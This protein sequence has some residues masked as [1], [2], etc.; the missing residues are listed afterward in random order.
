M[1]KQ[2][3]NDCTFSASARSAA[4]GSPVSERAS[5]P[6]RYSMPASGSRSPS[7]VA[8]QTIWAST[9]TSAPSSRS[10]KRTALM[11][12]RFVSAAQPPR[13][14]PATRISHRLPDIGFPLT[15]KAAHSFGGDPT[16]EKPLLLIAEEP[17]CPGSEAS[18]R[19]VM[20]H[21][22]DVGSVDREAKALVVAA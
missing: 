9:V 16:D 2:Q 5:A 14:P 8:S 3:V 15:E 7:S 1:A 4:W 11:R 12:S 20:I 21:S 18:V 10:R 6:V 13:L 22:P 19:E 17:L